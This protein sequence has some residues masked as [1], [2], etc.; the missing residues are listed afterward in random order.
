MYRL[1]SAGKR[2]GTCPVCL[3]WQ[4]ASCSPYRKVETGHK[5]SELSCLIIPTFPMLLYNS[6]ADH[7]KMSCFSN[8]LLF[9]FVFWKKPN[10]FT[11]FKLSW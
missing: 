1:H 11:R 10:K 6:R 3:P 9:L 4:K 8:F 7:F 2:K 5:K